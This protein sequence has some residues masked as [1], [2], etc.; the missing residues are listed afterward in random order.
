MALWK[1][2]ALDPELFHDFHR[3]D[4]LLSGLGFEHGRL[5]GAVPRNWRHQISEIAQDQFSPIQQQRI[6]EYLSSLKRVARARPQGA[7]ENLPWVDQVLNCHQNEPFDAILL[8]GAHPDPSVEN[9]S[10]G[11]GGLA[12]W[13]CDRNIEIPRTPQALAQT[14]RPLLERAYQVIIADAYFEHGTPFRNNKWLRPLKALVECLKDNRRLHRFE[15]NTLHTS[16]NPWNKEAFLQNC[17]NNIPAILPAGLGLN[18]RLWARRRNGPQFHERLIATD[19]G[20]VLLD[21]GLDDS[22]GRQGETYK[23][24]L[25]GREESLDYLD[26]YD[27]ET[28]PYDLVCERLVI[29]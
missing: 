23:L 20:G 1:E 5:L 14:L 12:S 19:I 26:K 6:T 16:K 13:N 11:L 2:Y 9:A 22:N 29:G 4:A 27:V 10:L 15:L 18:L 25:L 8:N 7:N 3:A 28:A 21:P 24:R 17:I